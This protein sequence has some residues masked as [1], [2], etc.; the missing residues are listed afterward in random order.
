MNEFS[1]RLFKLRK[2]KRLSREAVGKKIGVSKTSIKNWEDGENSPK[3]EHIQALAKFFDVDFNWLLSGKGSAKK[4]G[5]PVNQV[6]FQE[7][8][9]WDDNEPL[10]AGEVEI[11]FYKDLSFACG[12]GTDGIAYQDETRRLRLSRKTLDSR[13]TTKDQVFAARVFNNSME[14][15]INDG[16]TIIVDRSKTKIKDGYIFAIE[17][18]GLFLCKRLYR[19]PNN[20]IRVVSDN[21]IEYQEFVL[22]E[23]EQIDQN[24]NIIGW[25]MSVQSLFN[26]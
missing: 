20:G 10:D 8:S 5:T 1:E 12:H 19:M 3:V 21:S 4:D 23:Q 18:G 17:H 2:E 22:S 26:W 13:G 15:T 11:V 25:V 14:P 9:D 16:D 7:I 6:E 24:F